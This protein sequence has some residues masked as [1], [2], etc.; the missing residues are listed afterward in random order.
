MQKVHRTDHIVKWIGTQNLLDRL[1]ILKIADL[2]S[3]VHL[4]LF[5]QLFDEGKIFIERIL[6]L[7]IL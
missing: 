7:I 3:R 6:K 1:L 4:M 2:N 5:S